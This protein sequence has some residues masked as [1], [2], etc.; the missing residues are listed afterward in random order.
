MTMSE[1]EK[2]CRKILAFLSFHISQEISI[3][4]KAIAFTG[5]PFL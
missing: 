1:V 4:R 2:Y 5:E 3:A